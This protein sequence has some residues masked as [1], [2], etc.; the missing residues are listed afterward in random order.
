M[1]DSTITTDVEQKLADLV[2]D[3]DFQAIDRRMGRFNLFEAMGAVRG[4]LRH[5]NF[6]AFLLSPARNHGL[7]S[8]PLLRFLRLALAGMP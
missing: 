3:L 5:S 8:E 7:A 4:E 1:T 6:L 2:D